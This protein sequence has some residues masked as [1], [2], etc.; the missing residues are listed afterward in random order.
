MVMD[1]CDV[2][3]SKNFK[4]EVEEI[5]NLVGGKEGVKVWGFSATG[6]GGGEEPWWGGGVRVRVDWIDKEEKKVEEKV[7]VVEE[8][9]KEEKVEIV[10]EEKT[11]KEEKAEETVEPP[12]SETTTTTTSETPTTRIL[13]SLPPHATQIIHCTAPHKR[14]RKLIKILTEIMKP[15][16]NLRQKPRCMIFFD[17]IAELKSVSNFLER[18]RRAST[19]EIPEIPVHATLHSSMH[20]SIRTKTITNFKALKLQLLL[21]TDVVGRGID[22]KNLGY[23]ILYDFPGLEGWVHRSGR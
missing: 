20:Q 14:E 2:L 21:C 8:V 10:K 19:S 9:V 17:T 18:T 5:F 23:V 11:E 3:A 4:E 16:P 6:K 1:E 12:T 22:V 13:S 7:E 15:N